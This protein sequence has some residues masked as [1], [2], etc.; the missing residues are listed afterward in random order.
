MERLVVS[1]LRDTTVLFKRQ[2]DLAGGLAGGPF[3]RTGAVAVL[4]FVSGDA[5]GQGV[6]VDTEHGC[7]F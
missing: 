5:L 6:A 3:V 1:T 2:A 4:L 7:R